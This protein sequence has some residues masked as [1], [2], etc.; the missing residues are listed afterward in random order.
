MSPPNGNPC[1]ILETNTS[2][3]SNI[4]L[5]YLAVVS[6][7]VVAF[8][9]KITSLI[10]FSFTR[11]IKELILMSSTPIPA[12]KLIAPPKTW[13]IPLYSFI[14]SIIK[15][16]LI[17]STTIT[18]LW[19]RFSSPHISHSSIDSEMLWHLGQWNKSHLTLIMASPSLLIFSSSICEKV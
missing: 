3:S 7:S 1:A 12:A 9:A 4:T 11:S 6:P 8:V 5:I 10:V 15:T 14:F 16:S 19:S 2:K 18:I 17:V 13:Y